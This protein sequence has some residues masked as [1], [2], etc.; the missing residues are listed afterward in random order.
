MAP[1]HTAC[2][3]KMFL[4][5]HP[6]TYAVNLAFRNPGTCQC[7]RLCLEAWAIRYQTEDGHG[8]P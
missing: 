5:A 8:L 7:H 1:A 2:L 3:W 6:R 4:L